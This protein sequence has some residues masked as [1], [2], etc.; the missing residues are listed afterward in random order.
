MDSIKSL[1]AE[2]IRKNLDCALFVKQESL[3]PNI[4]YLTG[5]N[6]Y[7][8]LVVP[9]TDKPFLYVPPMELEVARKTSTVDVEV[10]GKKLSEFFK[11]KGFDFKNIGIDF[12]NLNVHDSNSLKEKL[13]V[14]ISDISSEMRALRSVKSSREIEIMQ[15]ACR[16]TD[17]ILGEFVNKFKGFETETDASAFLTYQAKLLAQGISF[18]PIVA[19]G[20]NAAMPHHLSNDKLHNGFCVVDFGVRY[21]GY[22][23]DVTRT[24]FIGKPSDSDKNIYNELLL[25]QEDSIDKLRSG[26]CI[27]GL[28]DSAKR[29]LG[30]RF[31]HS[32]GHGLGIEVHEDPNISSKTEGLF[33]KNMVVTIEPGVYVSGKYGIRIEDDLIVADGKPKAL[34]R[35]SKE[36]VILPK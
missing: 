36:L 6:G 27:S 35:F 20:A 26:V 12:D 5:Y 24:F 7:G 29:V 17:K 16:I 30:E 8:Y 31:T 34:S 11:E 33:K 13:A 23:S 22:C 2:L 4:L 18:E 3:Q 19:S 14:N 10:A 21:K 15:F 9:T 32:L 28:Y 1:Q 25:V